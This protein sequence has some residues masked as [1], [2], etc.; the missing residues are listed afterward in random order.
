MRLID[1]DWLCANSII[2]SFCRHITDHLVVGNNPV[3]Y[4]ALN[5]G[6]NNYAKSFGKAD[7]DRLGAFIQGMIDSAGSDLENVCVNDP[8]VNELWTPQS[9]IGLGDW[10]NKH[11]RLKR[12]DSLTITA[13]DNPAEKIARSLFQNLLPES[14]RAIVCDSL[15]WT[16]EE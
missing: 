2:L 7:P 6:L 15:K 12:I 10:L 16:S 13:L 4:R 9:N 8:L 14:E 1:V 11:N 5:Y 3:L